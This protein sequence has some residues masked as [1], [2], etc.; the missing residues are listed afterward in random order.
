MSGI[1]PLLRDENSCKNI[2]P[3]EIEVAENHNDFLIPFFLLESE[4]MV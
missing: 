2:F 4:Y 1:S 3:H